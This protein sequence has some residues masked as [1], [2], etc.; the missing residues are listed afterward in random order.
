[1]DKRLIG[2]WLATG[3]F[4]LGNIFYGASIILIAQIYHLGE[5]MPDGVF[6]WDTGSGRFP[7][8]W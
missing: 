5:Y 4:F 8:P 2:Y 7:E 1:M 3:L 6:W